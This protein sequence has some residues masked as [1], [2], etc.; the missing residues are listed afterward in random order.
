MGNN[1]KHAIVSAAWVVGAALLVMSV[2]LFII[3]I[4]THNEALRILSIALSIVATVLGF[5]RA[6]IR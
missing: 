2:I 1:P 4:A 3:A 5:V 6:I